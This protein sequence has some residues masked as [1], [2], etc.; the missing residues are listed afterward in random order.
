M[1][2]EQYISEVETIL[3]DGYDLRP[4]TAKLLIQKYSLKGFVQSL[5]DK[6][7]LT[8]EQTADT[9]IKGLISFYDK[10][11]RY[12]KGVIEKE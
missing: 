12:D 1:D 7:P 8:P 6:F 2:V 11:E 4:D 10:Q 9:M 5:G 3:V